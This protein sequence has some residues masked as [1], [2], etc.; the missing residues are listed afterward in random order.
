[1]CCR[2]E[3]ASEVWVWPFR[4]GVW[5]IVQLAKLLVEPSGVGFFMFSFEL[6]KRR[7]SLCL[8]SLSF[9]PFL[10]SFTRLHS[11]VIHHM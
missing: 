1:M 7:R 3:L 8:T 4:R 11:I 10:L 6:L 9:W 5:E 2:D